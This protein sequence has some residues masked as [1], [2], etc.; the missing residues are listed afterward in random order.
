[1]VKQSPSEGEVRE[2]TAFR[3]WAEALEATGAH[4]ELLG[5]PDQQRQE[6][7][8]RLGL[9]D[10]VLTVDFHVA[11]NAVPWYIDHTVVC[12]PQARNLTPAT[13]E[14]EREL[15]A[16]LT[17]P[18]LENR[19]F[20]GLAVTVVPQIGRPRSSKRD[21]YRSL[22]E[23]CIRSLESGQPVVDLTVD[24]HF[25]VVYP[26]LHPLE[27][28]RP[29]QINISNSTSAGQHRWTDDGWKHDYRAASDE[30]AASIEAKITTAKQP[31][32][33]GSAPGRPG[34]LRRAAQLPDEIRLPVGLLIDARAGWRAPSLQ[35]KATSSGIGAPV[36]DLG[37]GPIAGILAH[38]TAKHPGVLDC[39]WLL[40]TAGVVTVVHTSDRA[41]GSAGH[42]QHQD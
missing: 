38:L 42:H 11:I 19:R 40:D 10:G 22:A 27:P 23:S 1:M 14:A 15:T 7:S 18:L 31:R 36:I 9:S 30:F 26:L 4:I 16:L 32:T 8:S 17:G 28:T 12:A 21:Y 5:R 34:Q 3:D 13:L 20:G 33:S 35:P 37:P 39:A 29:I 24:P 2:A 6:Y 41:A 25:P